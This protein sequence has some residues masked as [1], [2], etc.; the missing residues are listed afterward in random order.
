[1]LPNLPQI[2]DTNEHENQFVVGVYKCL[3]FAAFLA[4][5]LVF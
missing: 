1:M 5:K 2:S 3:G 4:K